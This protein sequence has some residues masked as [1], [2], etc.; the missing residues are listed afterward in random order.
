MFL[1]GDDGLEIEDTDRYAVA[2]VHFSGSREQ[3][4]PRE[5]GAD[6]CEQI[7]RAMSG[8]EVQVSFF[9]QVAH[10]RF[11][12]AIRLNAENGIEIFKCD[13]KA[14]EIGWFL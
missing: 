2:Y 7:Q 1:N 9:L 8:E 4:R 14:I 5:T 6:G 13:E 3:I 11:Q 10:S 12:A